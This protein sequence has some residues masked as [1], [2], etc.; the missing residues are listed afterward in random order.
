MFPHLAVKIRHG[1]QYCFGKSVLKLCGSDCARWGGC[2]DAL[3]G[4]LCVTTD[5]VFASCADG[6]SVAQ[7]L[8][9][10]AWLPFP[11]RIAAGWGWGCLSY[12]PHCSETLYRLQCELLNSRP[13]T[14]WNV[15]T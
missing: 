4:P 13:K 7:M 12:Q 9:Q 5:G 10:S 14:I 8:V 1:D 3:V 11:S 2:H 15:P 6:F